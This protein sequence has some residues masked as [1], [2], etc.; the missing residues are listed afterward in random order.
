MHIIFLYVYSH[1]SLQNY[2]FFF[3]YASAR[4]FFCDFLVFFIAYVEKLS[5]L[6]TRKTFLV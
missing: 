3:I 6:C 2:N 1:N 4:P 5:Y